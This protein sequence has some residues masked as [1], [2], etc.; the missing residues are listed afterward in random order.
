MKTHHHTFIQPVLEEGELI[1]FELHCP[2]G[3]TD[4]EI[5]H[6]YKTRKLYAGKREEMHLRVIGLHTDSGEPAQV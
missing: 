2:A 4:A 3:F 5:A 6:L 1:G